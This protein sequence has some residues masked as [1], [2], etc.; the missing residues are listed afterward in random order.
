[1]KMFV[2]LMIAGL[3]ACG[4][5][6]DTQTKVAPEFP[7]QS[8]E[9][10]DV[11]TAFYTNYRGS[12]E[13]NS[14]LEDT[15]APRGRQ[16]F[17]YEFELNEGD[18]VALSTT[19]LSRGF[20][21]VI[22]LYGPKKFYGWGNPVAVNDDAPGT[23]NSRIEFEAQETGKYLLL[24]GEYRWRRGDFQVSLECTG[25]ACA[26]QT[27]PDVLCALYCEYGNQLDHNGCAICSCNPEPSCQWVNPAPWVRCA[28]IETVA[29]NP[30]DGTCCTYPSP[31]N[32][33]DGWETFSS[34]D[35]C[36]G[37]EPAEPGFNECVTD[38]DCFRTG[39]SGTVCAAQ[40]IY[41]T[42]EYRPEYACYSEPTTSCGCNNGVCGFAQTEELESCLNNA[43]L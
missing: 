27:C 24:V 32:V 16:Y 6:D 12:L 25:G 21:S 9:K 30:E 2:L 38:A 7:S 3:V 19:G 5:V 15:Y 43:G 33:P 36:A 39:C 37:D 8:D 4:E 26:A 42:C 1:M 23:L 31:C 10:S 18:V 28:G 41:T 20:D 22:G 13:M 14:T 40:T 34:Q 35:V 29:A 17:G 11:L